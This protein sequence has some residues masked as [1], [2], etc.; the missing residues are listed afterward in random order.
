MKEEGEDILR[1]NE[2]IM[3]ATSKQ[4][5][6]SRSKPEFEEEPEI[7]DPRLVLSQKKQNLR[8]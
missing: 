1:E 7:L 6:K 8:K 2:D 5:K 4:V 3:K